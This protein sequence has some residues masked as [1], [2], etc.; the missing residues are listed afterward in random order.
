MNRAWDDIVARLASDQFVVVIPNPGS[1]GAE[2]LARRLLQAMSAP[3]EFLGTTVSV[4]P[5]VGIA[6]WG[7][8]VLS[9]DELMRS[10]DAAM[11]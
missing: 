9:V 6:R 4:T 8:D 2:S 7:A 3:V 1:L 11:L 10:A 5:S